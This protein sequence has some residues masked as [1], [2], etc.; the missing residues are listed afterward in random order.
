[1][2]TVLLHSPE[3]VKFR[4]LATFGAGPQIKFHITQLL[5]T[6]YHSSQVTINRTINDHVIPPLSRLRG[7]YPTAQLTAITSVDGHGYQVES[8]PPG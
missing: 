4:H 1:L 8:G 3:T 5:A 7:D 2:A 6:F